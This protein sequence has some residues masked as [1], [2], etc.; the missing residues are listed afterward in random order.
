VSWLTYAARRL[1]FAALS[2]FLVVSATF[3][4]V[5]TAPNTDLTALLQ[6]VDRGTP[7]AE[8]IIR[9]YR[10][11]HGTQGDVLESYVRYLVDV[12]TLDWGYSYEFD[13]AV[14]AILTEAVP[15]TL[16]Y[17]VPSVL[18]AYAAGL[19]AG[20]AGAFGDSTRDGGL[21]LAVY[22]ALGVPS[23]VAGVA[24]ATA[25]MPHVPG[26][27]GPLWE[28]SVP[29]MFRGSPSFRGTG[30]WR[31]VDPKY[32]MP[33]GVLALGLVAGLA[34]HTRNA[35]ITYRQSMSAKALHAKGAST[36]V[37][38]RHA[39]RNAALPLLSVSFAELLSVLALG[40][41]VVETVFRIPGLAAYTQV[42]VYTRDFRLIV[43]AAAV[44]AFIGIAG[45][46]AQDLLYG[47]LDP[48]TS[49]E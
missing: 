22:V 25:A 49:S 2:A 5:R 27:A 48:R 7:E 31:S 15:R 33:A 38:A 16:A 45:S 21:R 43:G 37:Q 20:L 1:A 14:R 41:F 24:V 9:E 40:S 8:R 35:T 6:G 19:V 36:W 47:Y 44:Y 34:R 26:V 42:A 11:A 28:G 10:R 4:V 18:V 13:R 30:P 23:M 12:A 17:V 39:L 32:V 46:L 29:F 3:L